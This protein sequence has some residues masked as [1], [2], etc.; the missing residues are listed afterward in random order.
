MTNRD[1]KLAQLVEATKKAEED[2]AVK[3]AHA[4]TSREVAANVEVFAALDQER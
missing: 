2:P 3:E 4:H 1:E